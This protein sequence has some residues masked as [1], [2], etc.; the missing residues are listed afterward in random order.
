M[1]AAVAIGGLVAWSIASSQRSSPDNAVP[2]T[3]ATETTTSSSAPT[4]I[5]TPTSST[6]AEASTTQP[7]PSELRLRGGLFDA[8]NVWLASGD[9]LTFLDIGTG[10]V[11]ATELKGW[12]P[13]MQVG[14]RLA[15]FHALD[16]SMGTIDLS[17]DPIAES[18]VVLRPP[19]V[20]L[21]RPEPVLRD[22]TVVVLGSRQPDD[23]IEF[24]FDVATSSLINEE[25]S[26]LGIPWFDRVEITGEFQTPVAGGVYQL[27]DGSYRQVGPGAVVA[28]GE[29]LL[30]VQECDT[31][32]RC[33]LEWRDAATQR[34]RSLPIPEPIS[35]GRVLLGGDLLAY[36]ST[37]LWS[38]SL[39]DLSNDSLLVAS[40]DYLTITVE[41]DQRFVA[42]ADDGMPYVF[43]RVTGV[44]SGVEGGEPRL[45]DRFNRRPLL[46][47]MPDR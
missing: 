45:P 20:S 19:G 1:L 29:G 21:F 44:R 33:E 22:G 4:S 17:A 5:T 41:A 42:Y 38:E 9:P 10:A 34:V 39:W 13:L 37:D 6:V 40:A 18:L 25:A 32:L 2:P 3:T 8:T 27:V 12:I 7:A 16:G 35:D 43:D 26:D 28:Q 14:D 24:T 46:V 15:L 23:I 11:V 47:S 30:L 36:R 31:E